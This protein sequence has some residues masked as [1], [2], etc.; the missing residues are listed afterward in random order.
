MNEI[1]AAFYRFITA[2]G[3][4]DPRTAKAY[5]ALLKSVLG[6]PDRAVLADYQVDILD[7]YLTFVER[8]VPLN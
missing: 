7:D 8:V 2:D 1:L 6:L 5:C 3:W 4:M